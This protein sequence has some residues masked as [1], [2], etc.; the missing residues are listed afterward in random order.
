MEILCADDPF[1]AYRQEVP[2]LCVQEDA[3]RKEVRV[4]R[5]NPRYRLA[6]LHAAECRTHAEA[7]PGAPY[8]VSA[9]NQKVP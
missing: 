6:G 2:R 3:H 9:G 4:A 8:G 5:A 7:R 1:L